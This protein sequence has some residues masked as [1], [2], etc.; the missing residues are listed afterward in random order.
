MCD[1]DRV[2]ADYGPNTIDMT[3]PGQLGDNGG[4]QWGPTVEESGSFAYALG[5]S[6]SCGT[7]TPCSRT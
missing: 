6:A 5:R 4:N 1:G 3:D 7:S 2:D